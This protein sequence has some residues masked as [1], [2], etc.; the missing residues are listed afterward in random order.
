MSSVVNEM[1]SPLFQVFLQ[2][3]PSL[4]LLQNFPELWLGILNFMD[5]YLRLDNSDLLVSKPIT[6]VYWN[7]VNL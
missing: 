4:S 5:K 1:I 2:H 3:L 6:G 7:A